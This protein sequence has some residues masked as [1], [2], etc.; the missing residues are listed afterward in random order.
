[1]RSARI[2]EPC[3]SRSKAIP[4][5]RRVSSVDCNEKL[6]LFYLNQGSLFNSSY[7]PLAK[8]YKE[9]VVMHSNIRDHRFDMIAQTHLLETLCRE[10]S[11]VLFG[12]KRIQTD[13]VHKIRDCFDWRDDFSNTFR[14]RENSCL[15]ISF[16]ITKENIFCWY[17][18]MNHRTYTHMSDI[19][20]FGNPFS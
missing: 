14:K 17:T 20:Q 11:I 4:L 5:H 19:A 1:M 10:H 7:F 2:L 15:F 18:S 3:G 13:H 16:S 9:F 12:R 6:L 8:V